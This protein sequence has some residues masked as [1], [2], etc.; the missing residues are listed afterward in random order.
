MAWF[1]WY[2]AKGLDVYETENV[3]EIVFRIKP[4]LLM[5]LKA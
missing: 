2:S 1:S 3:M 4:D 5:I